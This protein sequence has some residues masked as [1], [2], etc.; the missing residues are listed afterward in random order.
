MKY[1]DKNKDSS[2]LKYWALNILYG[3][4]ISQKLPVNDFKWVKFIS[5][6]DGSFIKS[7][8]KESDEGYFFEVDIH[9]LENLQN[10]HNDLPFL[11]EI[12]ETEK[13]EKLA[14]NSH[15]RISYTH[16]KF[17]ASIKSWINF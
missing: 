1:Y 7:Y 12:M 2:Y 17:K 15:D 9:Q 6:F 13:V 5:E 11:P 4:L 10:L 8:N 16:K 3:W 14:T